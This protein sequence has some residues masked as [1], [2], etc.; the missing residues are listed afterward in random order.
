M[1]GRCLAGLSVSLVLGLLVACGDADGPAAESF[2]FT[3]SKGRQCTHQKYGLT[4]TCDATPKP[5]QACA[6]GNHP[7]FVVYAGQVLQS[8]AGTPDQMG[9]KPVWNCDACCGD[10]GTA[11][12]GTGTDCAKYVCKTASDCA[13]EEGT[14][15]DGQCRAAQ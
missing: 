9:P 1:G 12:T 15:E 5:T 4:A 13:S 11:W 8:P 14:C 6:A 2:N 10:T 3:D 7:C